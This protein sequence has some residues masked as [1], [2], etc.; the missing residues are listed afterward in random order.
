MW[1]IRKNKKTIDID[2]IFMDVKNFPGYHAENLEGVLEKPI[3]TKVFFILG[4]I[5]C[6]VS[7]GFLFRAVFLQVV[8]GDLFRLRS[9]NNRLRFVYIEQERGIIYDR[10]GQILASNI[11]RVI[12][13]NNSTTTKA[14]DFKL[15]RRYPE[16]GFLHVLG[17][18][19]TEVNTTIGV[20][21]L[22]EK[23]DDILRGTPNKR[24]EEVSASGLVIGSGTNFIGNPGNGVLTSLSRNLQLKLSDFINQTKD[25]RGFT[26]GAGIVIDVTNGEILAL[27]SIPGF[28]PNMLSEKLTSEE[29]KKIINDPGLPFFNRALFGLYPPGSIV[30]PAIAAGA[31]KEGVIDAEKEIITNGQLILPNPYFPDKP[32]IF[33]DWKNHGA[34]DMRRAL[35]VSSDVYFYEIGGGFQ[36]QQGLGAEGIK[37][38]FR[39]FGFGDA[40]GI[41]IFGE[42]TGNLPDITAKING[43]SWSVGDTYHLAIGQGPL[44]VTPIQIAVYVAAIA[45]RG[46][47]FQP[48]IARAIVDENKNIIQQFIYSPKRTNILPNDIF[49]VIHDGMRQSALVGTASALGGLPIRVAAKTG[50]AE[51]GKTGRVHSWSI[52]FFPYEKPRLAYVILMESGSVHNLVGATYVASQMLQWMSETNFLESLDKPIEK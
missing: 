50:T 37:K 17:Y 12:S 29:F 44:L 43:R 41:D 35:A 36:S 11:L 31:L 34:V 5:F 33:L 48:H 51:I 28:N 3:T 9:D 46:N 13:N 25:E 4:A 27:T 15:L 32:S 49:S 23:Y 47:I 20:S 42:K 40:T 19:K 38:Y 24:I 30:K 39:L 18:L 16:N 10:G 1:Q 26:G 52:G 6:I 8:N 14:S 22:E 21:G 7:V 45:S 2:E